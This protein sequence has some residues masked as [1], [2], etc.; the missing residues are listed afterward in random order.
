[1]TQKWIACRTCWDL[2]ILIVPRRWKWEVCL[3]LKTYTMILQQVRISETSFAQKPQWWISASNGI[4]IVVLRKL[5][6]IF[7]TKE[8]VICKSWEAQQALLLAL[9][10]LFCYTVLL[11]HAQQEQVHFFFIWEAQFDQLQAVHIV[12]GVSILIFLIIIK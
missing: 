3:T 9:L 8:V 1:M 2:A 10:T 4:N 6:F 5:N 12:S 7:Q 11:G